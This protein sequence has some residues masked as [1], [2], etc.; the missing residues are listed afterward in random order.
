MSGNNREEILEKI[1]AYLT[2]VGEETRKG[3]ILIEKFIVN[4]QLTKPPEAY[5]DAKTQ[6]HVQVAIAM[7]AKG[8]GTRA[9]DTIPYVICAG[10]ATTVTARAHH[11]DDLKKEDCGLIIGAFSIIFPISY[12][13][14]TGAP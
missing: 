3:L 8:V 14:L 10:D 9:G 12:R 5:A 4:K 7:K 1:H 2:L 11:P 13:Y 6:P